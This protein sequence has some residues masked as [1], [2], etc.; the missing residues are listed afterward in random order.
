MK[1]KTWLQLS[2]TQEK[3]M[4]LNSQCASPGL[5]LKVRSLG[6]TPAVLIQQIWE[7]AISVNSEKE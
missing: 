4:G 6:I 2:L 1:S 5:S 3:V 7:G